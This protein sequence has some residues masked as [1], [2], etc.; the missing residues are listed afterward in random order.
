[1]VTRRSSIAVTC[2]CA[3]AISSWLAISRTPPA[4]TSPPPTVGAPIPGGAERRDILPVEAA[5]KPGFDFTFFRPIGGAVTA[6]Q[7]QSG[8]DRKMRLRAKYDGMDVGALKAAARD[9]LA[10]AVRMP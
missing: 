1:M 9:N 5:G 3:T 4:A 10:R 6:G 7:G 8:F 2:S